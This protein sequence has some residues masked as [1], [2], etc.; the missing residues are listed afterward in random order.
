VRVETND[1][2]EAPCQ[3]IRALTIF[4]IFDMFSVFPSMSFFNEKNVG[5][6]EKYEYEETDLINKVDFIGFI[7]ILKLSQK[8]NMI[9]KEDREIY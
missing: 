6:C 8:I 5:R 7:D 3:K 2:E 9:T 4:S 1:K